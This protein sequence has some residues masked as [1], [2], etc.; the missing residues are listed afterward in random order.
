VL[1]HVRY[2]AR[3]GGDLLRASAVANLN[4]AIDEAVAA[5]SVRLFSI[6]HEFPSEWA[7]FKSVTPSAGVAA[8]LTLN[9]RSEHYPFWS[10]GRLEV[11]KRVELFAQTDKASLDVLDRANGRGAKD[12]LNVR[13]GNL[14]NGKLTAIALPAPIGK[15]TLFFAD[16]SMNNLW[17]ALTWG[18]AE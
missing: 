18:K 11:L 5:G 4:K 6:R 3:E 16:S 13:F 1:L 10:Q 15:F 8:G 12:T 17:L 14:L 9:L 7:A 2:T